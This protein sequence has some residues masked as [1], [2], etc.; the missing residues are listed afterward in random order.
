MLDGLG[1]GLGRTSGQNLA[2]ELLD[3]VQQDGAFAE[4]FPVGLEPQVDHR[5]RPF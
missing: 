2:S 5:M 4:S 3:E 1:V